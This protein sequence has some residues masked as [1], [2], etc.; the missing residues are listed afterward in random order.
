VFTEMF[1]KSLKETHRGDEG[2]V[3]SIDGLSFGVPRTR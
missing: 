1:D 2:D 3:F